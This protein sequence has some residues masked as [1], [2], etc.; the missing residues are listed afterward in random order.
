MEA[1]P[2]TASAAGGLT[3]TPRPPRTAST[4]FARRLVGAPSFSL[5][6]EMEYAYIRADLRRLIIIA[7]G[8]L[9]LMMVILVI[10]E[11]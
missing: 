1:R 4:A 6:R 7:G 8:L 3:A 2:S 11:R 9:V 5:S 10:V